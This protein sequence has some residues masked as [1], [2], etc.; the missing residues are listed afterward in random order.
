MRNESG[1]MKRRDWIALTMGAPVMAGGAAA[2]PAPMVDLLR[3]PDAVS[4]Y[5]EKGESRLARSAGRWTDRD[6]AV[7]TA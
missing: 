7:E 6:I 5:F 4:A 1:R 2:A 3:V